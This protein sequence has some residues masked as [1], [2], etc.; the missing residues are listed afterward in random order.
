MNSS[1]FSWLNSSIIYIFHFHLVRLV[2]GM[3]LEYTFLFKYI[4]VCVYSF[5]KRCIQ[6]FN[7]FKGIWHWLLTFPP[8][9]PNLDI[10][11]SPFLFCLFVVSSV[12][13][14]S[15]VQ[16]ISASFRCARCCT[17]SILHIRLFEWEYKRNEMIIKICGAVAVWADDLRTL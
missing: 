5:Q 6:Q 1:N 13:R 15:F 8:H 11:L 4:Y 16:T 10:G 9:S 12:L 2:V 14:W 7:I 3:Q 17:K